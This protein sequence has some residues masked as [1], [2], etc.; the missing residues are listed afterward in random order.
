MSDIDRWNKK[1]TADSPC[2]D[3]VTETHEEQKSD[4]VEEERSEE[5]REKDEVVAEQ[6]PVGH[7]H[8]YGVVERGEGQKGEA[9]RGR[10]R[11]HSD[12]VDRGLAA[13]VE[14]V[15]AVGEVNN[16]DADVA[17]NFA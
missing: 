13:V 10:G 16:L 9:G 15:V 11:T 12:S 3:G 2:R 7:V 17:G 5:C 4:P 14:V 1:K 8:V 6:G